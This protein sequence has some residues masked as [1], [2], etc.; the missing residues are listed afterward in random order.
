MIRTIM[1]TTAAVAITALV[2]P[3]T[4]ATAPVVQRGSEV[5][6]K[7]KAHDAV[8]GD[9]WGNASRAN[10]RAAD[11]RRVRVGSSPRGPRFTRFS[12]KTEV[13]QT[14]RPDVM[15][16]YSAFARTPDTDRRVEVRLV[17]VNKVGPE[18]FLF[19]KGSSSA[20]LYARGAPPV[21]FDKGSDTLSLDIR[22]V[23]LRKAT[24]NEGG[25]RLGHA[26]VDIARMRLIEDRVIGI[27][28]ASFKHHRRLVF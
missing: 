10:R 5:V 28:T 20:C 22:A 6:A 2:G 26:T 23:C 11:L 21:T 9:A 13:L 12:W 7:D 27:D 3:A 16:T 19:V 14:R 4:A 25:L 8:H 18:A 15:R 1:L 17:Q 24:G